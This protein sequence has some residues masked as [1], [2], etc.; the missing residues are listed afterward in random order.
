MEDTIDKTAVKSMM[1]ALLFVSSEPL[2]PAELKEICGMSEE[3]V[4]ALMSEM[5]D[6]YAQRGGGILIG[7]IAGGYQ[8]FANPEH[9]AF[10]RKMKGVAKQPQKLSMAAMETLAIIAYRQ[11]ITKA[12]VESLRGV[13]SDGTVKSLLDKRFIRIVGKKEVP[14]KP[15]LYGTTKDF[16][17]YFG[18]GDLTGLPTLKDF[19]REE[20]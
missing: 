9:N 2:P 3:D 5:I 13:N 15:L 4:T 18:L 7:R 20:T 8:M 11:P 16:L 1:E 17:Q 10:L 19:E 12:E 14:G 6:D